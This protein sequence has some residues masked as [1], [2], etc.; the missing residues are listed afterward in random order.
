M[1]V[2]GED[3]RL[4]ATNWRCA[5]VEAYFRAGCALDDHPYYVVV[6]GLIRRRDTAYVYVAVATPHDDSSKEVVWLRA[7]VSVVPDGTRWRA[8]R[9]AQVTL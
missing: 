1:Q 7:V 9:V 3:F 6:T 5:A 8:I 4:V 2:G